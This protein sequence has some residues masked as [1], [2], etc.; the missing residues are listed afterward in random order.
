MD[1]LGAGR[2]A[3]G[4]DR[5]NLTSPPAPSPALQRQAGNPACQRISGAFVTPA[6]SAQERREAPGPAPALGPHR[7]RLELRGSVNAAGCLLSVRL[8]GSAAGH[9][10][11]RGGRGPALP[12]R[13]PLTLPAPS[14]G[15]PPER[16][17]F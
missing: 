7:P 6:G 2:G 10:R 14:K 17:P 8:L 15:S 1:G 13:A 12:T 9:T 11:G 4:E 3:V 16:A 5:R